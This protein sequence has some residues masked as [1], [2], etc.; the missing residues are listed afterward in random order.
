MDIKPE[1][2]A[3]YR[4]IERGSVEE[5]EKAI[6]WMMLFD[7]EPIGGI[8]TD[9][10]PFPVSQGDN[11]VDYAQ[12]YA[13]AMRNPNAKEQLLAYQAQQAND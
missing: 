11:G 3:Y 8:S 1:D 2:I 9:I 10:S 6:N 13:Q 7:W 12:R 5:L 4:V